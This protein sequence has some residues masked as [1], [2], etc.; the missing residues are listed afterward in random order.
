M[1]LL[2]RSAA[3][4]RAGRKAALATVIRTRGSVP[5]HPGAKMLVLEDG[6]IFGTIGGGRVELATTEEAARVAAGAPAKIVEYHLVRDLAM[7]CGGSM[8]LYLEPLAASAPAI[9]RAAELVSARTP[10]LLITPTDGGAK[11][12]DRLPGTDGRRRPELDGDRFIEPLWPRPRVILFGCGHVARAIGPLARSV[13]F[14]IVVCDDDETGALA[15]PPAWADAVVP[16]FEVADVERALGPLGIADYVLI[17]TRDHGIDQ[18][19]VEKLLGNDRLAY[20]GL[21]GSLGKIGRFE[22]RLRAKGI[23][24]D[25]SWARLRAPIG[26]DIAAETPHEIAVAVVAELVAMRN[27]GGR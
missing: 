9:E 1:D 24:D 16:S 15:E 19:L 7:C 2:S 21:I 20:L 23:A 14:E 26:L 18:R 12:V 3:L 4:I 6:S 13:E 8:T 25:E 5:R 17:L 27:R 11:S 10:A 22:K